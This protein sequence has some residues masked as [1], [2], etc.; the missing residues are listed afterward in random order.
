MLVAAKRERQWWVP[1]NEEFLGLLSIGS[2]PGGKHRAGATKDEVPVSDADQTALQ[3][4][5]Q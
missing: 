1:G 2:R 5:E 4:H 3:H